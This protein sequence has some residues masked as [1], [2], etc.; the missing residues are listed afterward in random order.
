MFRVRNHLQANEIVIFIP[1]DGVIEVAHVSRRQHILT[2]VDFPAIQ[3]IYLQA[4]FNELTKKIKFLADKTQQAARLE[5]KLG[6][7]IDSKLIMNPLQVQ[8]MIDNL[9]ENFETIEQVSEEMREAY[10]LYS[11]YTTLALSDLV[12]RHQSIAGRLQH[13]LIGRTQMFHGPG[14]VE[15][16]VGTRFSVHDHR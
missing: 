11:E 12:E 8:D 1:E 9:Q 4:R 7:I 14:L 13:H 10:F 2:I 3:D 16:L 6:D 15:L 5:A